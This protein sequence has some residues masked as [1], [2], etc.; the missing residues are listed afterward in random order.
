M[1]VRFGGAQVQ[2]MLSR[3]HYNSIYQA[4]AVIFC[5][6]VAANVVTTAGATAGATERLP[7]FVPGEI[8]IKYRKY[9]HNAKVRS[10]LVRER[11]QRFGV[12]EVRRLSGVMAEIGIFKA[13]PSIVFHE[14]LA[15][16]KNDS[17]VEFAQPNYIVTTPAARARNVNG[18]PLGCLLHHG[19]LCGNGIFLAKTRPVLKP[20]PIDVAPPQTDPMLKEAYSV[21]IAH[22]IEAW[23]I[24]RGS[25]SVIVGVV[26]SGIDYNHEDLA[27]NM[28]RN[29][30]PGPMNDVVGYDFLSNNGEPYDDDEMKGHGTHAAGIIGAVGGNGKG[31]SGVNQRVS[32]MALKAF[33]AY[34]YGTTESVVA[35]IGYAIDHGAKIVSNSWASGK[36]DNPA[37]IDMI[38]KARAKGVLLVFAAGNSAGDNDNDDTANYPAGYRID[39]IVAVAST[40]AEDQLASSSNFGATTVLVAAPGV[41]IYSTLP[42]GQYGWQSGTS[43]ACPFAAGTAAQIWARHPKWSHLQVRKALHDSVDVLPQ[44]SGKVVSGG[45]V[46]VY[47]ALQISE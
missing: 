19:V 40:D 8:I 7:E 29:P 15:A 11:L 42:G 4:L 34:G 31:I 6:L 35:A 14:V 41:N 13:D 5:L 18:L 39:N 25:E 28:W 2:G 16:L 21:V 9:Q 17:D 24:S 26:D 44:L 38:E 43:M 45:R 32:L 20:R 46:N 33:S 10:D 23:G 47:K 36:K 12:S 37:V 30:S 22:A 27:F 1:V 3:L